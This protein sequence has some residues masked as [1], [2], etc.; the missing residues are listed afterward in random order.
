MSP[1]APVSPF[2][3]LTVSTLKS[4]VFPSESAIVY[5]AVVPLCDFFVIDVMLA[6]AAPVSP[7]A[8]CG[9]VCPCGPVAPVSPF[10]P[11][12]PMTEPRS[13]TLPSVSVNTSFPASVTSTAFTPREISPPIVTVS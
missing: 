5:V 6:P 9:P 11:C 7:F 10:G 13:I 4:N 3:P 2:S 12:G 8:P 1:F